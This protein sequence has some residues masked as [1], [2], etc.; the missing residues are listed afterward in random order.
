MAEQPLSIGFNVPF[1]EAIAAAL[2]RGV[3]L[4]DV[5]YGELQGIA[6]QLA[7]TVSGLASL[8]Q[9]QQV[10]DSLDKAIANG[11]SFNDWKKSVD[12][13]GFGLPNYRL[14]NIFRT[15]LQGQY[16][17]GKWEQFE[18]NKAN[19]PYLM[20]DAIND[21][22]VRPSHLALDGVIRP[23]DDPYW[24]THSCPNGF[25]CRCSLLSLTEKQAQARS[26][27]GKGLNKQA[28]LPDGSLAEPDKGWD[29][30]PRDRLAGVKS[31]I[32]D[33]QDK[34]T[35][36]FKSTFIDMLKSWLGANI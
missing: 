33:K 24:N 1:Y 22:R 7:F 8:D 14:D 21:S 2:E 27:P 10:K 30:S 5:Y 34:L 18:R 12:A 28:V 11:Q 13:M 32:S 15:N 25:R 17:A 16:M 4:P 31:A 3:V 6:R 35:P 19:R 29:Y 9:I 20:Y 23:V 26:G 36:V